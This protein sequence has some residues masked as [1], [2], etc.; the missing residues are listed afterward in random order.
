MQ[1]AT[2]RRPAMPALMFACLL[3]VC[4]TAQALEVTYENEKR[5][6]P[7]SEAQRQAD[8]ALGNCL[9]RNGGR[10]AS[11]GAQQ[12]QSER[13]SQADRE[14]AMRSGVPAG[15]TPPTNI[16][17]VEPGPVVTEGPLSTA[18]LPPNK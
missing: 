5:A 12:A 17:I 9:Y 4:A 3:G 14:M 6:T 15:G 16:V 13:V 2:Q 18:P 11:C 10:M 7:V 1:N 8:L